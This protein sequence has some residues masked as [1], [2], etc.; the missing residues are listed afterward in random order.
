MY[1]NVVL[2]D[3]PSIFIQVNEFQQSGFVLFV[4][5]YQYANQLP[6]GTIVILAIH[7]GNMISKRRLAR[8]KEGLDHSVWE[9]PI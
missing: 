7:K 2:N 5:E 3:F 1:I 8:Q 6:G 4:R 9:H